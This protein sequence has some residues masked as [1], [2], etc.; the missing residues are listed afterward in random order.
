ML[1]QLLNLIP[2]S[3]VERL[4]REHQADRYLVTAV[5]FVLPR[6][7]H[8]RLD[9]AGIREELGAMSEVPVAP[10]AT[11]RVS[12]RKNQMAWRPC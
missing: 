4:G 9:Y 2:R 10:A 8:L 7:P 12:I 5:E 6:T 11:A 3:L 1:S